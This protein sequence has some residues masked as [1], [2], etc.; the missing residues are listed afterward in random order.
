MSLTPGASHEEELLRG[1]SLRRRRPQARGSEGLSL[2]REKGSGGGEDELI[3]FAAPIARLSSSVDRANYVHH[4]SHF[5]RS[6]R[7]LV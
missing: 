7:R 4:P 5:F 3:T 1:V 6:R 2:W